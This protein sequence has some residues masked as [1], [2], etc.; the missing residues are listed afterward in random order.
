M[1]D[2]AEV[3]ANLVITELTFSINIGAC[4]AAAKMLQEIV[5]R[6]YP[7]DALARIPTDTEE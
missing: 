5:D 1:N 6:L 4:S 7:L 3:L 2:D